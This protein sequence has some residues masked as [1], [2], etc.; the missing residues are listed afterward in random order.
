[1]GTRNSRKSSDKRSDLKETIALL[2]VFLDI[3]CACMDIFVPAGDVL[4]G[5]LSLQ[6]F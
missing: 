4:P 6:G 1:V 2:D 5:R 3:V